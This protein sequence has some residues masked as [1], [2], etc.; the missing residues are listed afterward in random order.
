MKYGRTVEARVFV[1][2]EEDE[3]RVK[4]GLLLLF[5][6]NLEEQKIFIKKEVATGLQDNKIIILTVKLEKDR[7]INTFIRK[8]FARLDSKQKS[9]LL[10]QLSSRIDGEVNFFVR[11]GKNKLMDDNIL[12]I[13]DAGNCYHIKI[14]IAAYPSKK[15]VGMKIMKRLL[16]DGG[17]EE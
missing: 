3:E 14:G 13:T 8:L 16:D 4:S 5:P 2:G 17:M 10:E 1:K 9:L 12:K 15:A 6:Y 11:F 7:H